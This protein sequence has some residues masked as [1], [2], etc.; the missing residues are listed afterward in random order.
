MALVM[1]AEP[2]FRA[3]TI[4][5]RRQ[6]QATADERDAVDPVEDAKHPIGRALCLY[7]RVSAVLSIIASCTPLRIH[8]PTNSL[9]TSL[10]DQFREGERQDQV[11]ASSPSLPSA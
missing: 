6:V 2:Q 10:R 4:E 1:A 9:T 5:D 3:V 11:A 7:S 8:Q